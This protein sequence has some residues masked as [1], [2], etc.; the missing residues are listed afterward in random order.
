MW[1]SFWEIITIGIGRKMDRKIKIRFVT[2]SHLDH[3]SNI[4]M[5]L[6]IVIMLSLS[7]FNRDNMSNKFG[8]D[9]TFA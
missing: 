2:G 5:K 6:N 8:V 7:N 4:V 1:M 9:K 3:I